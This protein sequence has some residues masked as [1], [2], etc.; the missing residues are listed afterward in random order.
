MWKQPLCVQHKPLRF[1]HKFD[2]IAVITF[3]RETGKS[4]HQFFF[5]LWHPGA[6]WQ[7]QH[8]TAN[9]L[10]I[11]EFEPEVIR[12]HSTHLGW[13]ERGDHISRHVGTSECHPLRAS[14]GT[15]RN[16][17]H[18]QVWEQTWYLLL[19][20]IPQRLAMHALVH[21][22]ARTR[23]A[24]AAPLKMMSR[25]AV[26]VAIGLRR[27]LIRDR[28]VGKE[29]TGQSPSQLLSFAISPLPPAPSQYVRDFFVTFY[30][31]IPS[32]SPIERLGAMPP[33]HG[34]AW[35]DCNR[36]SQFRSFAGGP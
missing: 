2:M 25:D 16:H 6:V 8:H 7:D 36:Y 32:I 21:S 9:A 11:R 27:T 10:S 34:L 20:E 17:L 33:A 18:G 26:V 22:L 1:K 35:F 24:V 4:S 5:N 23:P 15:D 28:L 14:F 19:D 3:A 30:L 12:V 31:G 13:L 29:R